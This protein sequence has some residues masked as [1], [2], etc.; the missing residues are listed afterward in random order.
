MQS[1]R[2]RNK[3]KSLC[4]EQLENRLPLS[5]AHG[6]LEATMGHHLEPAKRSVGSAYPIGLTP[7]ATRAYYGFDHVTFG[8][9]AADG[10][11]QTIAIVTARNN[12][13]IVRDLSV[14]DKTFGL[15]APPS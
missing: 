14:F 15:P 13:N 5:A 1:V 11:G 6:S 2:A 8:G 9:V 4:F 10:E 12:P 7:S 3:R